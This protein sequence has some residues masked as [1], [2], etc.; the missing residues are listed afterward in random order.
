MK[1]A[2]ILFLRV[3]GVSSARTAVTSR[4]YI[5]MEQDLNVLV[6]K[7]LYKYYPQQAVFSDDRLWPLHNYPYEFFDEEGEPNIWRE[8]FFDVQHRTD[9]AN[10]LKKHIQHALHRT[11]NEDVASTTIPA[12][13]KVVL[14]FEAMFKQFPFWKF[15][16]LFGPTYPA[17]GWEFLP[18]SGNLLYSEP[19]CFTFL[20]Y[21]WLSAEGFELI[22]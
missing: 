21:H 7:L 12:Q 14:S 15:E 8:G 6:N 3:G 13:L 11:T 17:N 16:D 10:Q 20:K 2:L 18:G 22:I 4:A 5:E 19:E 1:S 9:R